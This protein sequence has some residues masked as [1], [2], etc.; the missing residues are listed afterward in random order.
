MNAER[1]IGC[2][3]LAPCRWTLAHPK[4]K[5]FHICDEC[6]EE[7]LFEREFEDDGEEFPDETHDDL[8]PDEPEPT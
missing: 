8:V 4:G 2:Q 6:V 7:F 5:S 3:E 1:C